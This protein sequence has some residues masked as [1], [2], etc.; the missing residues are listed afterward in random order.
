[1]KLLTKSLPN[2]RSEKDNEVNFLMFL[3]KDQVV[4]P[5]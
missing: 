1:M 2:H 4:I 3:Y 5:H